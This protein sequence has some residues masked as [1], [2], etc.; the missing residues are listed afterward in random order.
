MSRLLSAAWLCLC[1]A[2]GSISGS[3]ELGD[4]VIVASEDPNLRVVQVADGRVVARPEPAPPG[5][6][7][8]A[9]SIDGR[10]LYFAGSVTYAD[11]Q[12]LALDTRSLK[13][14][15]HHPLTDLEGRSDVT[16]LELLSIA[17]LAP[18]PSDHWLL[19]APGRRDGITGV[20]VLAGASREP[21][22]FLAPLMVP[23]DGMAALRASAVFPSG[24]VVVAG[25]REQGIG[26]KSGWLFFFEGDSLQLR[27]SVQLT[28]D[29]ESLWGGLGQVVPSPDGMS[30]YALGPGVLFKYAL[31]SREVR[32]APSVAGRLSVARDGTV[33]LGD[34][35]YWDTQPSSGLLFRYSS[36]LAT[37]DSIDLGSAAVEGVGPTIQAA[38]PS[39]DGSTVYV[40]IGNARVGVGQ[41]PGQQKRILVVDAIKK[42]VLK[43]FPLGDWGGTTIF[44]R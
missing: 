3:G 25:S 10:F 8:F 17:A 18:S 24:A 14:Q 15:W 34:S 33:Y 5:A 9:R 19:I 23:T 13:V 2:C 29:V 12:V 32:T 41:F 31:A 21:V 36:D 38:A 39:P 30:V 6:Y 1:L 43:S 16:G 28:R 7:G 37:V 20:A 44:V 40:L 11:R 26:P 27:D 42:Q 22:A 35:G 4:T